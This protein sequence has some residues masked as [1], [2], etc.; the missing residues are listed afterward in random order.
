MEIGIFRLTQE[1]ITNARKHSGVKRVLVKL[2]NSIN[3]LN[4]LIKDEGRG[5]DVE[6]VMNSKKESYGIIGMKERAELFGGKIQIISKPGEGTKVI[7]EVPTEG[8]E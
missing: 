4:L 2:E 6:G 5:F 1:A 8:E 7:V 3:G